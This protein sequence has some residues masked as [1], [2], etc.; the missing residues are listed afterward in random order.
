MV[1]VHNEAILF[2]RNES[3]VFN[4]SDGMAT[5]NVNPISSRDRT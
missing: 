4:N 2:W 1:S 3:E 5:P